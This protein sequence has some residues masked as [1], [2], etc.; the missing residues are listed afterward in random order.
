VTAYS[1]LT[2]STTQHQSHGEQAAIT[3]V[4]E[5]TVIDYSEGAERKKMWGEARRDY[6]H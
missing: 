2:E 4:I 5:A 1:L 6:D 3:K